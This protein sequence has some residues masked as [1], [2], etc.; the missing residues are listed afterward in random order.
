MHMYINMKVHRG[1]AIRPCWPDP[2]CFAGTAGRVVK[3]SAS[4]G[5]T[6]M[7]MCMGSNPGQPRKKFV[8]ID[9]TNQ[10]KYELST[11]R[12]YLHIYSDS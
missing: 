1:M 11:L 2:N 8:K 5:Y 10:V 6:V 9:F 12:H 3:A 7:Y 4:H